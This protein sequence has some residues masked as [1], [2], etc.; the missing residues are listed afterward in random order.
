MIHEDSCL[1]IQRGAC[2]GQH[3]DQP[4][5]QTEL[6]VGNCTVKSDMHMYIEL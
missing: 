6:C 3:E 5:A 4:L 2:D 1:N